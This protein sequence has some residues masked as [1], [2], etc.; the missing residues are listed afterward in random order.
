VLEKR[1]VSKKGLKI[2]SNK[3]VKACKTSRS[4]KRSHKAK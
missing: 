4:L 1:N 3:N 2:G